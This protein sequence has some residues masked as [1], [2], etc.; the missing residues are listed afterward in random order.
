MKDLEELEEH[1][2]YAFEQKFWEDMSEDER[3][4]TDFIRARDGTVMKDKWG[5]HGPQTFAAWDEETRTW[6]PA[7][8]I[9]YCVGGGDRDSPQCQK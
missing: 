7:R 6:V 3:M 2:V 1:I 5:K 4:H 8:F 9:E